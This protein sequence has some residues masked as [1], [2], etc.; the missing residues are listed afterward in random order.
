MSLI[1]Y[2]DKLEVA[3]GKPRVLDLPLV[4]TANGPSIRDQT[5]AGDQTFQFATSL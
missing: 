2:F 3:A 4:P 1:F 5:I